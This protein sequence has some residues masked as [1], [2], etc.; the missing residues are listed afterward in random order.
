MADR[1]VTQTGKDS[2]GDITALCNPGLGWS[3]RAKAAAIDDIDNRGITY[4]AQAPNTQPARI[5]TYLDGRG[6]KHLRTVADGD[7]RNNLDNLHDCS[8][9]LEPE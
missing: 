1:I 5:E 9:R 8:P 2:D 3:P 7:P 4:D 6:G